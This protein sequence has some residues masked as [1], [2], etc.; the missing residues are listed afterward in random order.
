M[1]L[2]LFLLAFFLIYGSIHVYFFTRVRGAFAPGPAATVC[3][4]LF[5]AAM[6]FAPI[7]VHLAE[8]G[9]LETLARLLAYVGYGWMGLL[10][11]FFCASLTIGLGRLLVHVAEA[12]TAKDFLRFSLSGRNSF[13]IASSLAVGIAVYGYFE[14]L[15]IHTE[16]AVIESS[17]IPAEIG[18]I[19]LVQISDVHLGLIV[20]EDRLQ[21]IIRE[22]KKAKP[23]LL[24]ST[25]DLV[26]G[27][28]NDLSG[29]VE[30][31]REL[32]PRYGKFAV[33]G[34]HEYYAGIDQALDFTRKAGFTVL[35]GEATEAAGI[36]IAGVNDP[37]GRQMGA[38]RTVTE[39]DL[40]G[41]LPGSRFT[42]FLKHRPVVEK[43]SAGLFDLQLSGHI[44]K[45]QIFPFN[46]LTRL[47]YPVKTGFSRLKGN[48]SL[49][50]SRGTGTWGPPVRFL[51]P[52]EIAVIDL[53]HGTGRKGNY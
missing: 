41:P 37:A 4:V 36:T 43:A 12:V 53:V 34:N 52:P 47:F 40:L 42:L 13:L 35:E 22:I 9:G 51:A 2:R 10:F 17:K 48:A 29:L 46:L 27:Q 26:D 14:A 21:R 39:R 24:L 8:R 30:G 23:D 15:R 25:G 28:I 20:R 7:L 1:F 16:R 50:V 44:H 6:M 18:R 3:L 49:Y 19:R 33:T 31:L 32:K 5:L 11:L 38:G 45:G